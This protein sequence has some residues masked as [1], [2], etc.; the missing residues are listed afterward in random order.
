MESSATMLVAMLALLNCQGGKV[1]GETWPSFPHPPLVHPVMWTGDAIPIFT[2]NTHDLRQ[3][4][5]LVHSA[6][7]NYT[8]YSGSPSMCWAHNDKAG[9]LK[10][11]PEDKTA[12]GE[13]RKPNSLALGM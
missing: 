1:H 2:N 6:G 8:G 13:P 5:T 9:S 12:Y 4:I 3:T 7:F 10:V 11:T